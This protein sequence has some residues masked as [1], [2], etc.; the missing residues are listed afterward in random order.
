LDDAATSADADGTRLGM[1]VTRVR[2]WWPRWLACRTTAP[3]L[4][5]RRTGLHRRP[6][7]H[8]LG[9][10]APAARTA[11]HPV[12]PADQ[13]ARKCSRRSLVPA[14]TGGSPL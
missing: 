7:P 6:V 9:E 14:A 3:L 13:H 10:R 1:V 11:A 4:H 5:D 8:G 12:Q 2:F